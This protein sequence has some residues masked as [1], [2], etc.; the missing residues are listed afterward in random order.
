MWCRESLSWPSVGATLPLPGLR[1]HLYYTSCIPNV[2]EGAKR[3]VL[4]LCDHQEGCSLAIVFR[5]TLQKPNRAH[6]RLLHQRHQIRHRCIFLL[7]SHCPRRHQHHRRQ[8][9]VCS[10]PASGIR[11]PCLGAVSASMQYPVF[12][13][14]LDGTQ[15]FS[16]AL[17]VITCI[18]SQCQNWK[19]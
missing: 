4:N 5:S 13:P 15:S 17:E 1:R 11:R 8:Y 14:V 12:D 16:P 3:S 18:F 6:H 10:L 9:E 7:H 19:L 2:K